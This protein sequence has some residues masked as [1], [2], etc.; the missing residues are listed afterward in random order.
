MVPVTGRPIY[1]TNVF[2]S[3]AQDFVVICMEAVQKNEDR[4]KMEDSFNK[5]GK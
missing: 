4:K 1:H 3:I 2:M 5:S